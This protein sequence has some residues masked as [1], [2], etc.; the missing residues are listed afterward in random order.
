MFAG[1]LSKLKDRHMQI[2]IVFLQQRT[3]GRSPW[4]S[5]NNG[6]VYRLAVYVHAFI[7]IQIKLYICSWLGA[8]GEVV[9]L[10]RASSKLHETSCAFMNK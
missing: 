5:S 4:A 3:C 6:H 1:K 2:E 7:L 8:R 10:T 9:V